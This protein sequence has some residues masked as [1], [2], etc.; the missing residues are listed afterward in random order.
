MKVSIGG[1]LCGR[2]AATG[3]FIPVAQ[4]KK[5]KRTAVV[6]KVP[7]LRLKNGRFAR[8]GV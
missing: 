1:V 7:A 4:A 6:E 8:R 5:R 2:D 3:R